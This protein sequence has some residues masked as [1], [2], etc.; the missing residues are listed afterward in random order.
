MA[1]VWFS[2]SSTCQAIGSYDSPLLSAFHARSQ[3]KDL[4]G[5]AVSRLAVSNQR[6]QHCW[7]WPAWPWLLSEGRPELLLQLQLQQTEPRDKGISC[8]KHPEGLC[9]SAVWFLIDRQTAHT[10]PALRTVAPTHSVVKRVP[11]NS[12]RQGLWGPPTAL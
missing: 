10:C 3:T 6:P 1:P 4:R 12:S 8:H 9:P 2:S 5:A 7:L 11:K